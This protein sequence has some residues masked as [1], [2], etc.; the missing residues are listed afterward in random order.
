MRHKVRVIAI[1]VCPADGRSCIIIAVNI[2]A[3][4]MHVVI[5]IGD[6]VWLAIHNIRLGMK[7]IHM[8][9]E[10]CELLIHRKRIPLIIILI[11]RH[12]RISG[13]IIDLVKVNLKFDSLDFSRFD[14]DTF[15][16]IIVFGIRFKKYDEVAFISV[17]TDVFH[18]EIKFDIVIVISVIELHFRLRY[19]KEFGF[20]IVIIDF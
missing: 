20:I 11:H 12:H 16:S 15:L 14:G 18:I 4:Q 8:K 5:V 13:V 3:M 17:A 10:C 6:D 7:S 19:H 1:S 2:R 9:R